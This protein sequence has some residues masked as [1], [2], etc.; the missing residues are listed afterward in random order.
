[1]KRLADF[2]HEA[3]HSPDTR[4][5]RVV[6]TSIGILVAFSVILF[7]VE[8][9]LEPDDPL[10]GSLARA[11][12]WLLLIF[13][14]EYVLRVLS[15]RP[16]QVGIFKH[17]YSQQLIPNI[18]GRI[19]YMLTPMMLVDL[20]TV[21]SFYPALRGL[22][23][24][25]V[26]RLIRT[27]KIF[28]YSYPFRGLISAFAN[29]RLLFIFALLMVAVATFLGGV[30]VYLI[31][32]PHQGANHNPQIADLG[33]GLWWALVTM[34]TVGYGDITPIRPMGR[35]VGGIMM[36]AGMFTLA[37]FAG[38]VSQT[39]LRAVL[40]IREEQFR[41]SAYANHIV[42]CGY[43][44]GSRMLLDCLE[45][46]VGST[47]SK[48][49][50]F[51]E[52]ERPPGIPPEFTWVSG[53]PT[54]ESELD[55]VRMSQ[56]GSAIVVGSRTDLPQQADAHTIL[57][58]F[59]IRSF[60]EHSGAA[61]KR[62]FPL[63]VVAEILDTENVDHA[64]AAGADEVIETTHLGFSLLAH[65]VAQPGTAAI[66]SSVAAARA[67]NIYVDP[68]PEEVRLPADF[69]AVANEIKRA[70]GALMI[71]VRDTTTGTDLINPSDD[72]EVGPHHQIIYLAESPVLAPAAK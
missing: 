21:L 14:V 44:A 58:V 54:K 30:T 19:H 29:N 4:V 50:I 53:D 38:I 18:T 17:R 59:T 8:L 13:A 24:V 52:G 35:V 45:Q 42:V 51:A 7:I 43:D 65:A 37:L 39:L 36:I 27:G 10:R 70:R 62:V 40:T 11:D 57:T 64:L 25:R 72:L 67:H 41:M 68:V 69:C 48:I 31:E 46:E 56:A 34:T 63:H 12:H 20:L 9:A 47:R 55:K 33:D 5:F 61:E 60:L 49:V 26:L 3:F 15:Y 1:M 32:G 23:A 22:R 16:P 2:I 66:L 28:R 6:Q 71:G